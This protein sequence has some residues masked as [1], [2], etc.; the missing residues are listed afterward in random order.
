MTIRVAPAV[1]ALF[2]QADLQAPERNDASD[3]AAS[4]A[5]HRQQNPNSDHDPDASGWVYAGDLTDDDASGIDCR[6]IA[7][8]IVARRDRRVKYLIHEGRMVSSYPTSQCKAWTWRP[9]SGPNG[10]FK[11]L[12]VSVLKEWRNDTSPWWTARQVD[13]E[14][15]MKDDERD[16]LFEVRDMLRALVRPRRGDKADHDPGAID[17][18]DVLTKQEQ[19]R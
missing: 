5:R 7:R 9:Y 2:K 8:Q 15:D 4:S 18:G 6:E 19:T 13:Q 10:H 17:L 16:A 11:H 12:H 14:D 1:L 3:G